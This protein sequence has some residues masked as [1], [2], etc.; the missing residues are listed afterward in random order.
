MLYRTN[1]DEKG[2][3]ERILLY[4]LVLLEE[5]TE[6]KDKKMFFVEGDT[7]SSTLSM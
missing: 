5:G 7:Q 2:E 4:Q 3:V 1:L 6:I